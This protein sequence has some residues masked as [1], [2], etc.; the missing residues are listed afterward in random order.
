[1][2]ERDW[3]DVLLR[4]VWA[5]VDL[6]AIAHNV[7]Q[8][9]RLI[10][11]SVRLY[12]AL[13]GD[14]YGHGCVE[15][16]RTVLQAGAHGLAL[17]NLYE[18]VELRQAGVTAPMLLY[19][20]TP[21]YLAETVVRYGIT[22]TITDLD[23]AVGFS[24]RAPDGYGVFVK[25][26]SGLERAGIY[27]EDA[28]PVIRTIAA[29]PHLRLEGVYTHMHSGSGSDEYAHW[30]FARFAALLGRLEEAGIEVPVRLA[31]SSPFVAGHPEMRL[32]AID[33]GHLIFGLS[34]G[35]GTDGALKLAPALQ[36]LKTRI[37]QIKEAKER[38]H[39]TDEAPFSAG[40]GRRF[41]LLPLGWGDG[42]HREYGS[43][44]P[45]L[46]RGRRAVILGPVH[47]EHSRLDLTNIPEAEV[48][49]EVVLLGRQA[50]E[51]ITV[52]EVARR[53]S[54]LPAQVVGTLSKHMPVV[55]FRRGSF[56][57]IAYPARSYS[58]QS[59]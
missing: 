48:G 51:A 55:Y 37:V 47:Y 32:N 13:K 29:L 53:C 35:H 34:V 11:P 6:D 39:F 5:E 3:R 7:R 16:A 58:A 25:I 49:D 14:G 20:G 10:G 15:T 40:N 30:Q 42:L 4:P 23:A 24:R 9:T 8:I 18:C 45:A 46:V 38:A 27:A 54:I 22:P 26:D 1:M 31:A 17:A 50:G 19:A 2:L 43:G 12:A 56:H 21:A 41:G 59:C 36:A 52:E 44:G 57:R 33:P 28:L